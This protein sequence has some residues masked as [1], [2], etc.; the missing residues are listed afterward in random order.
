MGKAYGLVDGAE[1]AGYA[2]GP[3]LGTTVAFLTDSRTAVFEMSTVLLLISAA[4]AVM[5]MPEIQA[6]FRVVRR[7]PPIDG[8]EPPPRW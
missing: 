6:G 5:S 1:F 8:R 4:L 2:F 3:A 7:P